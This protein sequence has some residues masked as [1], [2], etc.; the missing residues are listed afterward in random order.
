[1]LTRSVGLIATVATTGA[2]IV[3]MPALASMGLAT[4][5][6]PAASVTR[7]FTVRVGRRHVRECLIAGPRGAT[8]A[9]GPRG[10]V[11]PPGARGAQGHTGD[12]GSGG[13]KGA[14]GASGPTGP[15]GS[16]GPQGPPSASAYALVAPVSATSANLVAAQS[17]NITAVQEVEAGV[18]CL[19]LAAPINPEA[20]TASVSPEVSYS[21]PEVPGVIALNAHHP[22]CP[23]NAFEVDTY[24]APGERTPSGGH[25]FTIAIP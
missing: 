12:K 10:F 11:G 6:R 19:T 7:C 18:Y 4:S 23:G 8:G 21:T 2:V 17:A 15:S 1:M 3:A 9:R 22:H 16:P 13:A 20:D 14:T 24:N 25:A 5:A